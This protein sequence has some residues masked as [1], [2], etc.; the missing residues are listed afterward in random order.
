MQL[1]LNTVKSHLL[2]GK[3]RMAKLLAGRGARASQP[4][5]PAFAPAVA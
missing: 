2:R 4:V 3:Q 1:P 5:R